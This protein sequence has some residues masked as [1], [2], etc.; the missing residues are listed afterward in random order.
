[1]DTSRNIVKFI[2]TLLLLLNLVIFFLTVAILLINWSWGSIILYFII[3]GIA[4]YSGYNYK[5]K[6]EEREEK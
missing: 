1:M 6:L 5:Q 4:I 2:I 3:F